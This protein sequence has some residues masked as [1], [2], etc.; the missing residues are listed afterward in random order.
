VKI[1]YAWAQGSGG[2]G[3]AGGWIGFLP[4]I[5]IFVI[6]YVLLILPQQKKQKKQL[7]M[8]SKLK[9]GDEVVT[10]AGIHGTIVGIDD[11]R[12]IV[13][14]RVAENVKLELDKVAIARLEGERS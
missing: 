14:L 11:K 13:V 6:M 12:G 2:P 3:G 10:S 1:D 5:L 9:K 7:E 8:L 4:I